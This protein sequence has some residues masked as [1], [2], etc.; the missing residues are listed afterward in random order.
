MD[1]PHQHLFS[2]DAHMVKAQNTIIHA[3]I[4]TTAKF[5]TNITKSNARKRRVV[6]QASQLHNETWNM[7]VMSYDS[8]ENPI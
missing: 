4:C 7:D 1:K 2:W 5:P 8:K 6:I 3:V